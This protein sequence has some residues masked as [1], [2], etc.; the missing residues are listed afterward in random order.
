MTEMEELKKNTERQYVKERHEEM[1][2]WLETTSKEIDDMFDASRRRMKWELAVLAVQVLTIFVGPDILWIV[3]FN[4]WLVLIFVR[5]VQLDMPRSRKI[6]EMMGA[7]K[8][9]EILGIVEKHDDNG[10]KRT[11]KVKVK[12]R[13]KRFK[14]FFERMGSKNKVEVYG[15][16]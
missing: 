15:Q 11:K 12:S 7:L 6:G 9:L 1:L 8:A 4:V 2:A 13:F 5:H 16:A 14:E 10:D 3:A